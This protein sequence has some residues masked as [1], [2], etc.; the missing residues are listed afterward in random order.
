L[1]TCTWP[2]ESKSWQASAKNASHVTLPRFARNQ[3]IAAT[4]FLTADDS[5]AKRIPNRSVL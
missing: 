3:P 5:I 4:W 1:P 2:N